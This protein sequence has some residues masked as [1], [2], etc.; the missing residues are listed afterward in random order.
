MTLGPVESEYGLTEDHLVFWGNFGTMKS[1][2]SSTCNCTA[3]RHRGCVNGELQ[4][5]LRKLWR[6][7]ELGQSD[8]LF[9]CHTT[10]IGR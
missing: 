6:M 8:L 7:F 4:F 2:K 1:H 5:N 9:S 10:L 3:L